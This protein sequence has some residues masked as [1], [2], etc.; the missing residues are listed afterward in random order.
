MTWN[1]AQGFDDK[2]DKKR[3]DLEHRYAGMWGAERGLGFYLFHGA[4]HR[5]TQDRPVAAF[6]MVRDR[7]VGNRELPQY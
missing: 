7:V 3:F 6:T 5:T 4:G 2:P 1:G